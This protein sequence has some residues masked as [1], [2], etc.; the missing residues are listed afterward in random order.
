ML[1]GPTTKLFI[2]SARSAVRCQLLRLAQVPVPALG[3][4]KMNHFVTRAKR[5]RQFFGD[6][7]TAEWIANQPLVR[8]RILHWR[9]RAPRSDATQHPSKKAPQERNAPGEHQ[10]P[11]Q[12]T[13]DASQNP[14]VSLAV[15]GQ[16]PV[17]NGEASVCNGKRVRQ[18][19]MCD[20]NRLR[21]TAVTISRSI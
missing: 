9:I 17:R 4:A 7:H 10:Q 14:H 6:V 3:R 15:S 11:K 8:R 21:G 12:K 20:F 13:D 19:K 18:T 16:R 2:R 5:Y 1:P